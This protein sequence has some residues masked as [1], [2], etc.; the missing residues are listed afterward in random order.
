M[1]TGPAGAAGLTAAETRATVASGLRA[2]TARPRH[3]AV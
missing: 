3:P 1:L 2:G